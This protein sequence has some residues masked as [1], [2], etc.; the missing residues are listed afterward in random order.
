L[1]DVNSNRYYGKGVSEAVNNINNVIN[2]A[3][4]DFNSIEQSKIDDLLIQLDG[5]ENKSK[6]GANAILAVSLA[7]AKAAARHYHLPLYKYLGGVNANTMPVPMMNILNGGEHASNN[8]DIQEFRIMPV[9]AESFSE[10]LRMGSEIYHTLSK[11][12]KEKGLSTT[13]G[14]E[15]G[16]APNLN[17]DEEAI[18]YILEAVSRAGYNTDDIKIALDA[19]SSE[20]YKDGRYLLPKRNVEYSVDE[21]ISY[22]DK[23]CNDYPII[24]IEDGLGEQDWSGWSNITKRLGN[25]IQLVG[26]DLFVTNPIHLR[27]G[28]SENVANAIL[29]KFNQIGTLSETLSAI[30]IAKDAGYSTVISHRSGE[31]EDTTIADLAVGINAGQIKTGAPCRTDRVAKYN[32]LLRIEADGIHKYYNM[33]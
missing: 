13:V 15:G 33:K 32:R 7:V 24:S 21:L 14:D 23:L 11:I 1:R 18:Q 28:I 4:I 26:D 29:I 20:W 2:P 25:K 31:T 19:A 6:L 16:F 30:Q 22:W 3:L 5:T 10:A 17:S 27:R 8:I 12:L 9:G